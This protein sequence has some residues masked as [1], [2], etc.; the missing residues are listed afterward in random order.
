[1]ANTKQITVVFDNDKNVEDLVR[2]STKSLDIGDMHQ[3]NNAV[4]FFKST[5][6]GSVDLFIINW[7][8]E[9]NITAAGIISRIRG[10]KDSVFTPIIILAD[11]NIDSDPS[12]IKEFFCTTL[13]KK[14]LNTPNFKAEVRKLTKETKWYRDNDEKISSIL[15]DKSVEARDQSSKLIEKFKTAPDPGPLGILIAKVFVG[16]EEYKSAERIL[17]FVLGKDP[18]NI[19]ALNSLGKV[20]LKDQRPKEAYKLFKQAQLLN[21]LNT[22]RLCNL[23]KL[24]LKFKDISSAES[25][26]QAALNLDS[27]HE[28]ANFGLQ[29]A[30]TIK[31][32]ARTGGKVSLSASYASLLNTIGIS[33]VHEG[34]MDDAL[35]H[36]QEALSYLSDDTLKSK[37]SFNIGLG[38]LRHKDLIE[39]HQWFQASQEHGQ[40]SFKKGHSYV[41]KLEKYFDDHNIL[42][43]ERDLEQ[44]G[45]N[46]LDGEAPVK[47][48]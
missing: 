40:G 28:K 46:F 6:L 43:A 11:Q 3:A 48:A 30:Q 45:E 1:M 13:I 18:K 2:Q 7:T 21:P 44:E 16:K 47:Q 34:R 10:H 25:S 39:A 12:L 14:P 5:R 41:Y 22:Q 17:Q 19:C 24:E 15:Q 38:F 27:V 32:Q 23:G 33:M 31:E 42:L 8:L 35:K 37:V 4:D 26:F 36:Y 29:L 9:D 20:Y